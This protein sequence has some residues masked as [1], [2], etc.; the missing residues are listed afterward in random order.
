MPKKD[1]GLTT[2]RKNI[3]RDSHQYFIRHKTHLLIQK[4]ADVD[5]RRVGGFL[6]VLIE[7]IARERLSQEEIA[8]I[9]QEGMAIETQRRQEAEDNQEELLQKHQEKLLQKH[10]KKEQRTG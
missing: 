1:A 5:A 6:D 10:Q 3:E 8:R 9:E 2:L 7:D 4:L